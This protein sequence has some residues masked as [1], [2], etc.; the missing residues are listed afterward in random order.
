MEKTK[1]VIKIAHLYYDLMNLYGES[2]NVKALKRFIE[3][4]N[5]ECEVHFLTKGDEIDFEAYDL[6]Y[7]GAGTEE[8]E[9]MVIA[10]L[11]KYKKA[12]STA[13]EHGKTFLVTGNAMEIFGSNI[14]LTNDRPIECLGVFTYT[15]LSAN[16]RLV[17][18]LFYNFEELPKGKGR[19]IV[20][21]KNCYCNI[22]NNTYNRPFKFQDNIRYKNFFGMMFVGPVCIRNPYFTDYILE[23]LFETKGL[24]Y[25]MKDD[26]IE[27][28]AYHKFIEKFIAINNLD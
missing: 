17:S 1:P 2:G 27:Y 19:Q 4:Q 5:V 22:G 9:F 8:A 28:E 13:I 10:D 25:R 20:G 24:D 14:R 23:N 15:S 7:M 3:R 21:F 16:A 6:F 18:D 12:I 11:R 26:T